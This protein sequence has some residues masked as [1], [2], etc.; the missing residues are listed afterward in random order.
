VIFRN[1]GPFQNYDAGTWRDLEAIWGAGTNDLWAGGQGGTILRH[2]VRGWT[3][4]VTKTTACI[5]GLWGSSTNDLWAWS[6]ENVL[7]HWDGRAWTPQTRGLT[8]PV[9]GVGGAPGGIYAVGEFGLARY[10]NRRWTVEIAPSMLGEGYHNLIGVCATD[11]H[12]IVGDS[13]GHALVRLR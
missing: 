3:R 2:D 1:G 10:A 7:L 8:G 6:D 9:K 12:V 11:R 5:R 13:G 4:Q